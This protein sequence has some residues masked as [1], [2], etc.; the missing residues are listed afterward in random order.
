MP[1]FYP[2]LERTVHTAWRKQYDGDEWRLTL[3]ELCLLL[4]ELVAESCCRSRKWCPGVDKQHTVWAAQVI[5]TSLPILYFGT[6]ENC[7]RGPVFYERHLKNVLF[8]KRRI[9]C[10]EYFRRV[11]EL[12]FRLVM[13]EEQI[14]IRKRR[15]YFHWNRGQERRMKKRLEACMRSLPW[16]N[17]IVLYCVD[18]NGCVAACSKRPR[19]LNM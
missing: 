12:Q 7:C 2:P 16:T 11:V 9:E 10:A 13:A 5:D 15:D 1:R 6:C 3:G 18:W 19:S 14:I 8:V 4:A 17:N